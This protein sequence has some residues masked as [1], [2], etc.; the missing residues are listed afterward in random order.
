MDNKKLIV[1]L[2]LFVMLAGAAGYKLFLRTEEGITATG[3]VEVTKVDITPKVSGYLNELTIREGDFVEAGQQVVRIMRP[4]LEAQVLRDTAALEKADV[5]LT[6]LKKGSRKQE[7]AQASANLAAA[8]AMFEKAK[9]DY[10]RYQQLFHSSA[11]SRQQLD[12]AKSSYEVAYNSLIAAKAQQNLI[13][14]GSR[15]DVITAQQL[16][17]ERNKAILAVSKTALAD[18]LIVSPLKGPVISKNFENGEYVSA[19]SP[20][21]TI[22]DLR[23]CWIKVYIASTQLGLIKIGQPVTIKIDSFPGKVFKGEIKEI[24]QNAEFTPRQSITQQERANTVFAV[25]IKIDNEEGILKPGMPA[26]VV[27][28]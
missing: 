17:V 15:P 8:E 22:A 7:Q 2:V 12:M 18:T 11:I 19:G 27:I 6:D 14:E 20:I 24:S 10:E 5:Q 21:A 23:D 9:N 1:V 3:T 4:D 16:E 25:K 13:E 28:K 26:D